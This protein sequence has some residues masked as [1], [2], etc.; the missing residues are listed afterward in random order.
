M[1]L[2]YCWKAPNGRVPNKSKGLY[3]VL[4]IL[5]E[6]YMDVD[7]YT[8]SIKFVILLCEGK[9]DQGKALD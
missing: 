4:L 8:T 6:R 5:R 9:I 1:R 3:A 7:T 2:L